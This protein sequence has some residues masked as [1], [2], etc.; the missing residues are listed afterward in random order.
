MYLR[1]GVEG[2]H[3]Q[4]RYREGIKVTSK[5]EKHVYE[6]VQTDWDGGS[7][8]KVFSKGKRGKGFQ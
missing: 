7:R 4:V 8:G 3:M 2:L 1:N 6:Q 5:G